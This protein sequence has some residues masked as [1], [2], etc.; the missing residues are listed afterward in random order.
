MGQKSVLEQ[1]CDKLGVCSVGDRSNGRFGA[2]ES[3]YL[4]QVSLEPLGLQLGGQNG[5][6]DVVERSG[7]RL[8]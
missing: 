1:V 2:V 3:G 4:T 7:R 5:C 8:L 6:V